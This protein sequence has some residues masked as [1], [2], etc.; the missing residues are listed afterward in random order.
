MTSSANADQ[1]SVTALHWHQ[2][3]ADAVL[4]L[5]FGIVVF[6]TAGLAL[7]VVGNRQGWPWVNGWWFRLLHIAAIAIVVAQAW[8]GATCPL[9]RLESWLRTR[10]G[11][12]GYD[13]SFIE[14]WVQA[15]LFYDAPGWV[16]TGAYTVFGL[17]V[18]AAWWYFPPT[19]RR[20]AGKAAPAG[21]QS[22]AAKPQRQAIDDATAR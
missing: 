19:A 18:V 20:R 11:G 4:L 17:L 14:H 22:R 6:V 15:A 10:S 3:L 9:T 12:A 13:A 7:I 8:L 1:A 21:Q 16:F 5:H 2:I